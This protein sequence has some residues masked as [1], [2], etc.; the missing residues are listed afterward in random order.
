MFCC[1][2]G[3]KV[4][5][6]GAFLQLRGD[7]ERQEL[8]GNIH[9]TEAQVSAVVMCSRSVLFDFDLCLLSVPPLGFPLLPQYFLSS[10]PI[11]HSPLFCTVESVTNTITARLL[12]LMWIRRSQTT[13]VK[14]DLFCDSGNK[15]ESVATWCFFSPTHWKTAQIVFSSFWED[16]RA[17]RFITNF[18]ALTHHHLSR[19]EW[20]SLSTPRLKHCRI[21]IYMAISCLLSSYLLSYIKQNSTGTYD[22]Q[23]QDLFLLSV[24]KVRTELGK[25]TFRFAASFT[26]NN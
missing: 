19:V 17:L 14:I 15:L 2:R 11:S 9:I 22:V 16:H 1:L 6:L 8:W 5:F 3:E 23:S 10:S 13:E 25:K 4:H 18:Q 7:A 20:S 12:I 26:W 21:L 24:P